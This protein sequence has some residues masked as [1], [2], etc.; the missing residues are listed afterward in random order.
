MGEI[1]TTRAREPE[2]AERLNFLC[3]VI[4]FGFVFVIGVLGAFVL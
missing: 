1:T 3:C 4:V 2:R